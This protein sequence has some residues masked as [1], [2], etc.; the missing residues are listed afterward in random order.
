MFIHAEHCY[1]FFFLSD[2]Y[3]YHIVF[4]TAHRLF[5]QRSISQA[6]P[7]QASWM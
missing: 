3:G 4:S 7:N 5:W 2:F 1:S 6:R